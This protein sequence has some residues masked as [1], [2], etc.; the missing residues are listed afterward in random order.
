MVDFTERRDDNCTQSILHVFYTQQ[1]V[2]ILFISIKSTNRMSK[3]LTWALI[4]LRNNIQCGARK[5]GPLS[6]RPTWRRSRTLYR[7]L[8]KCKCKVLTRQRRCWKWSPCT[9]MHFCARRSILSY[10]RC[11][12]AVTIRR[13]RA[14]IFKLLCV[15]FAGCCS[16]LQTGHITLSTTPDQQLENHSTKYHRQQPLYNTLELLMMG[17]VVPG[18]FEQAIRSAI[19][20]SVASSWHF[21]FTY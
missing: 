15:R 10:T 19:K 17:I 4:I 16:I 9:S 11:N 5:T 6:R 7:K 20:T 14:V 1:S 2:S 8:N 18:P 21:I 3:T 13:I 12:S